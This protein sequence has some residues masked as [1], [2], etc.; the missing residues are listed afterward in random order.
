MVGP[1]V[2]E[3]QAKKVVAQAE[4]RAATG[5]RQMTPDDVM[6]IVAALGDLARVVHDAEPADKA[7]IYGQLGLTLTYQPER[8]LVEAV[9]KPSLNVPKGFVSEDRLH[10]KTNTAHRS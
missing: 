6:A 4:I 9:I 2:A 10:Q 5:Q 7:E 3:T 8:R 1:W